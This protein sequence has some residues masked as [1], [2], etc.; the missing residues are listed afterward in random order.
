MKSK[1]AKQKPRVKAC[2]KEGPIGIEEERVTSLPPLIQCPLVDKEG[3]G[4]PS[5]RH[6]Q[7]RRLVHASC[8]A[9]VA[10]VGPAAATS[11]EETAAAAPASE[12]GCG[13]W[14]CDMDVAPVRAACHA[15]DR[16][17]SSPPDADPTDAPTSPPAGAENVTIS[18]GK[19]SSVTSFRNALAFSTNVLDFSTTSE[20]L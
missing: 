1:L 19:R 2:M 4:L 13:T 6:P 5:C 3:K 15:E 7:H 9:A 16:P 10:A 12:G 11:G 14:P 20:M 17:F 18:P 8:G